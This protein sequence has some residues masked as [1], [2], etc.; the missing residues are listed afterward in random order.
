MDTLR[1]KQLYGCE[2]V[3]DRFPKEFLDQ[4]NIISNYPIIE[5]PI[6]QSGNTGGKKREFYY[7]ANLLSKYY[8]GR[9][10][11]C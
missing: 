3:K 7:N 1:T 2:I 8:G 9:L 11:K 4:C 6:R 5:V 10:G